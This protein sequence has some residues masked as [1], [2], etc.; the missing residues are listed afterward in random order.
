MHRALTVLLAA[1]PLAASANPINLG[2][3]DD[4]HYNMNIVGNTSTAGAPSIQAVFTLDPS[5][6]TASMEAAA[7]AGALELDVG[8]DASLITVG[9]AEACSRVTVHVY[10][11]G[12]QLSFYNTHNARHRDHLR[13]PWTCVYNGADISWDNPRTLILDPIT[14]IAT[15]EVVYEAEADLIVDSTVFD[16]ANARFSG[17]AVRLAW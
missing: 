1:F 11:D 10:A 9:D 5:Q 17:D 12:H 13:Q 15:L 3:P 6:I 2:T 7:A 14:D 4:T 8:Y 16:Q